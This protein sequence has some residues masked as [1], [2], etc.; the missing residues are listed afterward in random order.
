MESG[1]PLK[2][3]RGYSDNVDALLYATG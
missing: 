2:T 3:S 1:I